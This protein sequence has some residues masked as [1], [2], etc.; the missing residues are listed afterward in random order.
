MKKMNV[1]ITQYAARGFLMLLAET[2]DQLQHGASDI[3][4]MSSQVSLRYEL[5]ALSAE[6]N[7]MT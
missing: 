1:R 5:G 3:Y 4:G 6:D 7:H 2:H